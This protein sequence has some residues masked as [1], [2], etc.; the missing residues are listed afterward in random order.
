MGGINNKVSRKENNAAKNNSKKRKIEQENIE[1]FPGKI[2]KKHLKLNEEEIKKFLL[3][4]QE[5]ISIANE[6]ESSSEEG[7]SDSV[8]GAVSIFLIQAQQISELLEGVVWLFRI[9]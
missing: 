6:E 1:G 4:F 9:P 8:D 5:L 3:I 2:H 7:G